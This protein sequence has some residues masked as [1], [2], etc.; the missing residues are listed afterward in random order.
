MRLVYAL[1]FIW[2]RLVVAL[3]IVAIFLPPDAQN[4]HAL[5]DALIAIFAGILWAISDL[6]WKEPALADYERRKQ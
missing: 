2:A 4:P 5:G 3:C 6:L 1:Y